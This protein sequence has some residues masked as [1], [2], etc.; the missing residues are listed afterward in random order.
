VSLTIIVTGVPRSGTSMQMQTLKILGMEI[1]GEEF[2]QSKTGR[3]EK[4]VER[5]KLLNPKG[6]YE[7][8]KSVV[9]G[10]Q[11]FEA[12]R[13]KAIKIIVD[14]LPSRMVER[15]INN[16][17]KEIMR[18]TSPEII[19]HSKIILCLRDP[20]QVAESQT[21]LVGNI[22]VAGEGGSFQNIT[23][24]LPEN[25]ERYAMEMG[26]FYLWLKKVR[27]E[28]ES[29]MLK[30]DF[31]DMHDQPEVQ[32]RKIAKFIC[33]NSTEDQIA[34]AVANVS[35]ELR[36][37]VHL[38]KWRLEHEEVGT[39]ATGLYRYFRYG[40]S[41]DEGKLEDLFKSKVL[42]SSSW[43]DTEF[44]L[45]MRSNPVLHRQLLENLRGVRDKLSIQR[46]GR[47][48]QSQCEH[49]GCSDEE[50]TIL[51]PITI[52]DLVRKKVACK[53]DGVVKTIEQCY[54]CFSQ[55]NLLV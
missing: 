42:E 48:N 31:D 40:E 28:L 6:F 1:V 30:I 49:F 53:K 41:I 16:E 29:K 5:S 18:G 54:G 39:L 55:G 21:N 8:R 36:R 10:S 25:P 37:S 23:G 7:D 14:G 32:I 43:I 45:W 15:K 35:K 51:R 27:P 44:D 2:P 3:D 22:H 19:D 4:A 24:L 12:L 9:R 34:S 26:R 11:D 17:T 20:L 47:K 50:Y 33:T 52:G 38:K 13:G 46:K